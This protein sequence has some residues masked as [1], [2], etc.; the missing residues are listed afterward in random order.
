M[1][2]FDT[3]KHTKNRRH[4]FGMTPE[5]KFGWKFEMGEELFSHNFKFDIFSHFLMEFDSGGV[6]SD[7][8][9]GLFDVDDFAVYIMAE[10]LKSFSNLDC[11]H[12][13]EYG[14]GGACLGA[15][16][17][18]DSLEGC[19]G[20]FSVSFEFGNFVSALFLLFGELLEGSGRCYDTFSLRDEVVAA[21]TIFYFNDIVFITEVGYIFFKYDFHFVINVGVWKN[22]YFIRSVT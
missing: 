19:G 3:K 18:A 9:D 16:G 4:L 20:S 7:F 17:E 22:D 15:D 5:V 21:I 10:F 14:A 8:F 11:I 13:A 12:R 1:E 6:N 2:F